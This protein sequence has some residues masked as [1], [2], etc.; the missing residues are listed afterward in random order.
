MVNRNKPQ[1]FMSPNDKPHGSPCRDGMEGDR[2]APERHHFA[3]HSHLSSR[4]YRGTW[5]ID[6][7]HFWHGPMGASGVSQ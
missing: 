7:C 3:K 4:G 2:R 5:Q 1:V 6:Y